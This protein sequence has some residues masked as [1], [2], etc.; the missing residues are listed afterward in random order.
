MRKR[1]RCQ[2][3]VEFAV[4]APLFLLCLLT[5]IDA[6][7]WAMQT[8]AEVAVVQQAARLAASAGT[9]PIGRPAPDARAVTSAVAPRLA[10]ALFATRV[11]AWCDPAPGAA[12]APSS[13]S[14]VCNGAACQFRACPASPAAVQE[15]FGP[16]VVAVCVHEQAAP[17]CLSPGVPLYCDD[18]P[19]VTVRVIGYVASLVPPGFGIGESGGEL[20]TDM[21]A[22]THTLRFAP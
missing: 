9:A 2:A 1:S 8:S 16:R 17:A 22:T 21:G 11:V 19:T 5:T 14:G 15:V 18:T 12:C 13:Q 6:G 3:T 4:A 7:L 20:P 10:Q